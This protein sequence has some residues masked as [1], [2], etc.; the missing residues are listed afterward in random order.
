L[1]GTV[2]SLPQLEHFV[3]VST[4]PGELAELP[5]RFALQALHRFGSFLNDLS[6]KKCCSPAV[7]MKSEPQSMQMSCRSSNCPMPR[8][9]QKMKGLVTPSR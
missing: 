9:P 6:K 4:L 1:K 8:T 2:V 3:I 5:E 7:N